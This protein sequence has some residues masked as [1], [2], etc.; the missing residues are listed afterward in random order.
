[1]KNLSLNEMENVEGGLS[2][3]YI[4]GCALTVVATAG[5]LVSLASGVG[6][7]LAFGFGLAASAWGNN[8]DGVEGS[9]L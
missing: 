5:A 6:A 7:G 1:M 2:W 3:G 9:A 4:G 8:C